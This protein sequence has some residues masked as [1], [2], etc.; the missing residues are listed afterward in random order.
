M[1][2][3]VR[4]ARRLDRGILCRLPRETLALAFK[5]DLYIGHRNAIV[6]LFNVVTVLLSDVDIQTILCVCY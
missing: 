3:V 4:L 2:D 6:F 5:H 1:Y